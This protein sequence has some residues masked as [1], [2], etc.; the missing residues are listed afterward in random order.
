MDAK[1]IEFV[2][3]EAKPVKEVVTEQAVL[4]GVAED[5]GS[6]GPARIGG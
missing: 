6:E 5:R 3:A 2:E 4:A 1:T